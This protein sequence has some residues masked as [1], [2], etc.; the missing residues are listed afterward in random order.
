LTG[1]KLAGD[2]PTVNLWRGKVKCRGDPPKG[3]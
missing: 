2:P 1:V 3:V